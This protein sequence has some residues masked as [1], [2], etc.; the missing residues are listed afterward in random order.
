MG[1]PG[2]WGWLKRTN[3]GKNNR[4]F[5][6]QAQDGLFDCAQDDT[7]FLGHAWAPRARAN[8]AERMARPFETCSRMADW[9]P[10]AT[11]PEISRPRTIGPGWRTNALGACAARRASLSW[12]FWMYSARSSSRPA[13]RS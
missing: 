1:H 10:S 8:R 5:F 7:F 9:G 12:K 13:R 4:R 2:G 6:R 11:S 3:N